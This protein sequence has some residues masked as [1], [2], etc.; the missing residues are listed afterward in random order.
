MR[1]KMT[2]AVTNSKFNI[3]LMP[4]ALVGPSYDKNNI[5]DATS[6]Q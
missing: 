3:G 1:S 2:H 4:N 5:I 6:S